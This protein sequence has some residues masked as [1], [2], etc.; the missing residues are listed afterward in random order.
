MTG[1][2]LVP[3]RIPDCFISFGSGDRPFAELVK[4]QLDVHGLDVFLAPVSLLL[5]EHW[6]PATLD[7]L[8]NSKWVL[9]LASREACRSP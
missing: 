5:G 9:F 7:A 4:A 3:T 8:R 2:T 6:S 1:T